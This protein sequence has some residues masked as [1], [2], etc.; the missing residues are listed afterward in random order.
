M[1]AETP[2]LS[3]MFVFC[4]MCRLPYN[5]REMLVTMTWLGRCV[6]VVGSASSCKSAQDDAGKLE[7]VCEDQLIMMIQTNTSQGEAKEGE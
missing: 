2:L 7:S 5:L 4:I 1:C 6:R 3:L